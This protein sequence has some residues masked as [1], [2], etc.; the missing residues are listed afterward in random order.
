MWN[1]PSIL[2][3][4]EKNSIK[5]SNKFNPEKKV[6]GKSWFFL[7]KD[8]VYLKIWRRGFYCLWSSNST[9]STRL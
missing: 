4:L 3:I 8:L 6:S 1:K 7:Y 2:P 5:L 9:D